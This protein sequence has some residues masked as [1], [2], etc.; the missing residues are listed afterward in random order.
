MEARELVID[1]LRAVLARVSVAALFAALF[2]ALV[3]PLARAYPG[4]PDPLAGEW[5][6][7]A[8]LGQDWITDVPA[9]MC[10]GAAPTIFP[11][12]AY[13]NPER[14]SCFDLETAGPGEGEWM[15]ALCTVEYFAD[16]SLVPLGAGGCFVRAYTPPEL[17]CR[18]DYGSPTWPVCAPP[19]D[20]PP[21]GEVPTADEVAVATVEAASA[22]QAAAS[23]AQ[24]TAGLVGAALWVGVMTLG[25][26]GYSVGAR[27]A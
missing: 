5:T 4:Y 26:F 25:F 2:G 9:V 16:Y 13:D 27:D 19:E 20:P 21:E 10:L 11:P 7:V 1:A 22:A 15:G 24:E 23:A 12:F 6:E 17:A 14:D 18:L 3:A 8:A